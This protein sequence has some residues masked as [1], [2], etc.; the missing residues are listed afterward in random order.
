[1]LSVNGIS[2]KNTF[3]KQV[4]GWLAARQVQSCVAKWFI[5]VLVVLHAVQSFKKRKQES[6]R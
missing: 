2:G 3:R 6:T 1:M 5:Y 4:L